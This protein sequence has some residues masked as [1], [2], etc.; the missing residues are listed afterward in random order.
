MF[1]VVIV[2]GGIC[3]LNTAYRLQQAG[4]SICVLEQEKVIGGKIQ[5]VAFEGFLLEQGPNTFQ[6]KGQAISALC[7]E[8]NLSPIGASSK[9]KK[10][11]LVH[12]GQLEAL[13]TNPL[14]FLTSRILSPLAK[15]RLLREPLI[16]K[17]KNTEDDESVAEFTR[18][19]LGQAVL[20]SLMTPFL[21]GIYAGDPAKLSLPAVFPKLAEFEC[22]A[23]S[24]T[25]GAWRAAKK[26]KKTKSS[27]SPY[28]LLNFPQ[29]MATL[30]KALAEH[31][32]QKALRLGV[33]VQDIQQTQEGFRLFLSNDETMLCKSVVLA[34][35]AAM[36]AQLLNPISMRAAEILKKIPYTPLAVI[37]LGFP[38]K[39]IPHA[40][41]GFGFLVPRTEHINLL[42]S[43]WTSS[44][45][46]ERAPSGQILMTCMFGG[47]LHPDVVQWPDWQ[48]VEHCLGDLSQI[49]QLSPNTLK[50]T[51]TQVFR[52]EKAIPQY[53]LGHLQRIKQLKTAL[54]KLP[55]L[56][57]TGNYFQGVALNDC[58][59]NSQEVSKQV[60]SYLQTIV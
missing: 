50:P 19:R 12:N 40:L 38:E 7:T 39:A 57:L 16:P 8:L 22:S 37:H 58:I 55:G 13:P 60:A 47:A 29:G 3:G 48:L 17:L 14:K 2:G 43:I 36:S 9:A 18:R 20:D 6:S 51:I 42:G 31:L 28:Q 26:S 23:G 44:L 32:P 11:Y 10:R 30:P 33:G 46:P 25:L 24:L 35:P 4:F 27:E 56:F 21:T 52:Y 45:F 5:T 41:D 49:F 59:L 53:N 15:L 54:Q 1:D 34:T